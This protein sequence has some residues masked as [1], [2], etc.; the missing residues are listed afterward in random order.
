MARRDWIQLLA[1]ELFWMLAVVGQN[2][3]L[4]LLGLVGLLLLQFALSDQRL[5]DLRVLP[6]ALIGIALDSLLTLTGVFEFDAL[7]LWLALLWCGFILTLGHGLAWMRTRPI[8]QQWLLGALAGSTSYM[9]G[10]R[11]EAVALPL[12]W[13]PSTLLLALI[14]GALLP[15]LVQLDKT[16]RDAV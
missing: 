13:I 6:L 15:L 12:G 8:Y 9:S 4:A 14:W 10:W 5:G 2:H 7:P 3:P 1:F 11:M 16:L